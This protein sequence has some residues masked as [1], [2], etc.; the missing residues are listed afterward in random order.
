MKYPYAVTYNGITYKPNE[1][2]PMDKPVDTVKETVVEEAPAKEVKAFAYTKTDVNRM[3]I[4]D[5]KSV[6]LEFGIENAETKSGAEL[7]KE[8]ITKFGL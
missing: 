6:A 1:E 5:L 7:K 8:L 3:P 2:I 4:G